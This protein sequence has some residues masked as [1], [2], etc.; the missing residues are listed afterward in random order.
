M[1]WS[2]S[3]KRHYQRIFVFVV[4]AIATLAMWKHED[5]LLQVV[6]ANLINQPRMAFRP[7][8]HDLPSKPEIFTAF[9]QRKVQTLLFPTLLM[10]TSCQSDRLLRHYSTYCVRCRAMEPA[11][12]GITLARPCK[13]IGLWYQGEA[14]SPHNSCSARLIHLSHMHDVF[15][16]QRRF[17]YWVNIC[18]NCISLPSGAQGLHGMILICVSLFF[19]WLEKQ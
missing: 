19:Y 5:L 7:T 3:F 17:W 2:S 14:S 18:G 12:C 13:P 1:L 10:S 15:Q 4:F 11:W 6:S 16:Q 9:D 8:W